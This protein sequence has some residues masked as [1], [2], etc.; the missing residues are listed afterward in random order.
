MDSHR[1]RDTT[2]QREAGAAARAE[3]R[4]RLLDAAAAEFAERG[5]VGTTVTRVAERAGV[6]VQ[7]LY[8]AWG[9]KR[10]LLR[11]H[12]E[13]ALLGGAPGHVD[14]HRPR[15]FAA[16]VQAADDPRETL[17]RVV[18]L[19]RRIAERAGPAWALHRDAA[20]VDPE[21]A[22]DWQR[23]H[24]LRR[25]TFEQLLAHLPPDALRAGVTPS[26]AVDTAWAV[27]SPETYELLVRRAG[28]TLDDY[29]R[30]VLDT[31]TA[32]LLPDAIR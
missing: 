31:L 13:S 21:I 7:T 18:A 5:Y 26:A 32:A 22:E 16:A 10:A 25:E 12:L 11:A 14:E 19:Y 24:R 30:W 1:P 15:P 29:E 20:A 8:L 3:T 27:A 6:T 2:R 17:R 4:R 9:S 28:H 23:W